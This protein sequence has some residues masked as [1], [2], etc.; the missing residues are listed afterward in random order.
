MI[1]AGIHLF[2][3]KKIRD[4]LDLKVFVDVD[5]DVRLSKQVIRDSE[6]RYNK[7]LDQ[8]LQSYIKFVKPCFEE[9]ILPCKKY[10]DVV[11]PRG[12]TNVV[13][14]DLLAQHIREVL[15]GKPIGKL[16]V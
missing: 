14:I 6:E 1:I 11:I 10:A 2:Y 7:K 8:I 12:E 4:I 16:V 9:F 5:S 3:Q 13:A 15:K